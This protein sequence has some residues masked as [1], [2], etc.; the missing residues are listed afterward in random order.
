MW[1]HRAPWILDIY[2]LRM[3]KSWVNFEKRIWKP[4]TARMLDFED[5]GIFEIWLR[6]GDFLKTSHLQMKGIEYLRMF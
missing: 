1:I 5:L 3:Y 4:H 6:F 2:D